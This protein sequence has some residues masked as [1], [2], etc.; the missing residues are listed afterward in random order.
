MPALRAQRGFT[1]RPTSPPSGQSF[2]K[3]SSHLVLTHGYGERECPTLCSWGPWTVAHQIPLSM[4]FSR[5]EYWSGLLFPFPGDLPDPGVESRSLALQSDSL[6][7]EPPST[8]YGC[9]NPLS[10]PILLP[11]VSNQLRSPLIL[12]PNY[13]LNLSFSCI[14]FTT[15]IIIA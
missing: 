3:S 5:Q 9:G 1:E 6:P 4:G 14:S 7:S 15:I 8:L 10:S 12:F 2:C 11:P 13:V